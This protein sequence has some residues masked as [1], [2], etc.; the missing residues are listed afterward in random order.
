[1]ERD[2]TAWWLQSRADNCRDGGSSR[3]DGSC[4]M[5]RDSGC[6]CANGGA[7]IECARCRDDGGVLVS[8]MVVGSPASCAAAMAAAV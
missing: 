5:V 1:V 4:A 7:A 8:L 6:W 3:E 2:F